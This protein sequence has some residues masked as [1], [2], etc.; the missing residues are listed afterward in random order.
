MITIYLIPAII[1]LCIGIVSLIILSNNTLYCYVHQ[2]RE[3]KL[4]K[5]YIKNYQQF[6]YIH[7]LHGV[8]VFIHESL[9]IKANVWEDRTCSIHY[10]KGGCVLSPYNKRLSRKMTE[11]LMEIY[12][13]EKNNQNTNFEIKE[14]QQ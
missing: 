3:W 1:A 8:Y 14:E 2:H 7:T 9:T 13:N 11:K 4:W 5:E 12:N 6:H 10:T